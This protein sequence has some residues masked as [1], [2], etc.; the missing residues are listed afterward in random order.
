MAKKIAIGGIAVLIFWMGFNYIV[1]HHLLGGLYADTKSLWRAAEDVRFGVYMAV[2]V[3]SAF[4]F[5]LAYVKFVAPKSLATG[6]QFGLTLG[7]CFGALDAFVDFA[8]MPVPSALAF[9]WFA[10]HVIGWTVSGVI[11]G[12]LIKD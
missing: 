7:V 12:K 9:G 3:V 1:H 5:T 6:L 10:A 11:L 4:S 8:F 2:T